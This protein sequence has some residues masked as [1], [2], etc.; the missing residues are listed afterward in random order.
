MKTGTNGLCVEVVTG[1]RNRVGRVVVARV[2][3]FNGRWVVV[4]TLV[5]SEI[6]QQTPG[7]NKLL[8]HRDSRK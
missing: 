3:N 5:L 8:K 6:G 1:L 7:T 2:V 4:I